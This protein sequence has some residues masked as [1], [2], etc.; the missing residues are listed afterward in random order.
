MCTLFVQKKKQS[1]EVE[2]VILQRAIC[3][4]Q[5]V[6]VNSEMSVPLSSIQCVL[7]ILSHLQRGF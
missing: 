1:F 5:N 6:Q 3:Q 4:N 7:L 2:E